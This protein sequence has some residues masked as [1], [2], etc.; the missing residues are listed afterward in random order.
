MP[1]AIPRKI[2]AFWCQIVKY[3]MREWLLSAR[4]EELCVKDCSRNAK[5]G[6]RRQLQRDACVRKQLAKLAVPMV[7]K[8]INIH[9]STLRSS[10]EAINAGGRIGYLKIFVTTDHLRSSRDCHFFLIPESMV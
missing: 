1:I 9:Q 7:E 2:R 6:L 3:Q 10:L 4:P 8:I 5:A